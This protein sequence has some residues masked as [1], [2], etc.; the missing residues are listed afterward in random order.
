MS[1]R[2]SP[3]ASA[4]PPLF[5]PRPPLADELPPRVVLE[6]MAGFVSLVADVVAGAG[7]VWA[8]WAEGGWAAEAGCGEVM[9]KDGRAETG[10]RDGARVRKSEREGGY[11]SRPPEP[12]E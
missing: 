5:F 3:P 7:V 12:S 9:A 2:D 1:S 8:G 4:A 11:C 10:G 6:D